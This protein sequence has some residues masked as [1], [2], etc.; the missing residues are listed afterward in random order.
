MKLEIDEYIIIL[1]P[2]GD[3][4]NQILHSLKQSVFF[5]YP[6]SILLPDDFKQRMAANKNTVCC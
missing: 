2:Y 4:H 6:F 1:V 3:V 5:F